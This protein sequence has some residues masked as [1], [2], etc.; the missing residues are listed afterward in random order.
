MSCKTRTAMDIG[1][2]V[3]PSSPSQLHSFTCNRSDN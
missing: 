3:R 2:H 1:C